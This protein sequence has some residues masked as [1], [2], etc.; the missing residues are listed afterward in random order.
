MVMS[1]DN[2]CQRCKS[3]NQ[4]TAIAN[5]YLDMDEIQIVCIPSFTEV[6]IDGQE[7]K[8]VRIS[9]IKRCGHVYRTISAA[10]NQQAT[11]GIVD[12][13]APSRLCFREG[14]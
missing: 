14:G 3:G 1:P 4:G 12:K 7:R 8:A 5:G 2:R 6:A 10:V 13:H 9:V 11:P